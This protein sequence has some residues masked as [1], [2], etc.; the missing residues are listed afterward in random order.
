MHVNKLA[1]A[2]LVFGSLGLA[3]SAVAQDRWPPSGRQAPVSHQKSVLADEL[4]QLRRNI[5]ERILPSKQAQPQPTS[6]RRPAKHKS[7]TATGSGGSAR[8]GSIS[9][10]GKGPVGGPDASRRTSRSN[11]RGRIPTAHSGNRIAQQYERSATATRSGASTKARVSSAG[12][13]PIDYRSRSRK[14]GTSSPRETDKAKAYLSRSVTP[15][16]HKRIS[17]LSRSAFG[18]GVPNEADAGANPN[19]GPASDPPRVSNPVDEVRVIHAPTAVREPAPIRGRDAASEAA[20]RRAGGVLFTRNSPVLSVSTVGPRR[21][22]VGKEAVYEITVRNA[23]DVAAEDV[24]VFINLPEWADLLGAEAGAGTT[25]STVADEAAEPLQWQLG[26]LPARG[27]QRLLLRIVPRQRRAFDLAVRWECKPVA[28]QTVIEVQEPELEVQLDGP[29]E[30][31][32]GKQ[33]VYK[34]KLANTGNGDAEGVIIT[35]APTGIGDSHPISHKLGRLAAGEETAVELELTARQSQSLMIK[36]DV[37]ADG[38]LH[39]ELAEKVVVRRAVLEVDVEGPKM[40]YVGTAADYRIRVR[41]SGNA[42]AK[43]L[44]FSVNI[45]PGAKY[46]SGANGGRLAA[47]GSKLQWTLGSLVPGSEQVYEIK[48]SLGLPGSNHLQVVCSADGDVS[49]AG[50]ATTAVEAIADLVLEVEDPAVPVPVGR[51]ATYRIRIGNRGTKNAE[52]VDVLA[53]FSQGVEPA[54]AIGGKHKIA[55][56]EVVFAPISS[57]TAGAEVVFEIRARAESPGNHVFR[58][59]V[60][61]PS[62][63]TR[64][65]SEETTNFFDDSPASEGA[66]G[67]DS[68]AARRPPESSAGRP[69]SDATQPLR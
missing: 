12:K 8:A 50:D 34:L 7:G 1:A 24:T 25:R 30:V 36:V 45:P 5:I 14:Q 31:L 29:R 42:E 18:Q 55:P 56:G 67:T 66:A 58:A 62:L 35:L 65:V 4:D 21:I 13:K 22:S 69:R 68:P 53:Y 32:Y 54:S 61:C 17:N 60:H 3:S 38:G 41:N 49:A 23:A 52:D 11:P 57:V 10:T 6:T 28:S 19:A 47:D 63:Q 40:Q 15:P 46:L 64:L 16:I 27:Q 48:C 39:A 44:A 9:T 59:E 33:E 37:R 26:H 20:P 43:H 51:E 2:V